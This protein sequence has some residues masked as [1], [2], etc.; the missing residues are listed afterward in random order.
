MKA[1]KDLR[2]YARLVQRCENIARQGY[3]TIANEDIR[4][5]QQRMEN[6]G[7]YYYKELADIVSD[8]IVQIAIKF[9]KTGK[10]EV[11]AA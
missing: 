6:K 10:L 1:S 5:F 3:F 11:I 8:R 2:E 7:K 9:L 4:A